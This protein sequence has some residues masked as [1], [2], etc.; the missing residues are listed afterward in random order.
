MPWCE[1]KLYVKVMVLSAVVALSTFLIIRSSPLLFVV[2]PPS[3]QR[4][5]MTWISFDPVEEAP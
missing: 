1:V 3:E 4:D 5:E 2:S